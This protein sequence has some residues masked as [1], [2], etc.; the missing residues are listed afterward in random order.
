MRRATLFLIIPLIV[1]LAAASTAISQ[2]NSVM[3]EA[4][5]RLAALVEEQL[6]APC[7]WR[8]PLSQHYSGTAERMKED[9]REMLANGKTQTDIIEYYKAMYGER[10]LSSPPNAGFNRL[11][12]LFTP[13]MFLVGAGIIF[14][15]LRR[16]R[17]GRMSRGDPAPVAGPAADPRHRDRIDAELNAYD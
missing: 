8:A 10:I 16:W 2:V 3:A 1:L 6:I 7:C 4:R 13:L 9:L 17:A 12:Y 14:L 5:E 15:T 11:A